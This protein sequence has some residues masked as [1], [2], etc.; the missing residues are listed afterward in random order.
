MA[1]IS[2]AETSSSDD[3]CTQTNSSSMVTDS[4]TISNG[5]G[6]SPSQHD[7]K[8]IYDAEDRFELN[9]KRLRDE[10]KKINYEQVDKEEKIIN[11]TNVRY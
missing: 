1:A 5:D 7:T 10:L 11:Q 3:T 8:Q 2:L 9:F 6:I 4:S